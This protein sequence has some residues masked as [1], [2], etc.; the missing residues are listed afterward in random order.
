MGG[1]RNPGREAHVRA[2]TR[3]AQSN[4]LQGIAENSGRVK[5]SKLAED[6]LALDISQAVRNQVQRA[7]DAYNAT[8]GQVGQNV[9]AADG[10]GAVVAPARA[11]ATKVWK[12]MAVQLTYNSSHGDFVSLEETVLRQLFS[13]FLAFLAW[14]ARE[15]KAEGTS[16][17]MEKASP[18]Q[19][20]LHAYLHLAQP[21]H[22][23]GRDAL[24]VFEFEGVRPHLSPNTT[25]GKGYMG[26]VRY[27]HFYVVVDKIGTLPLD[28]TCG[29]A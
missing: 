25:S 18:L 26:A 3:L 22:R 15:L 12:F 9:G 1:E 10:G 8:F 6:I 16:A 29:V 28:W 21:F 4:G 14:L 19:V 7:L 11:P 17:T 2:L 27:G 13:R 23:R 24:H 5:V 20:H